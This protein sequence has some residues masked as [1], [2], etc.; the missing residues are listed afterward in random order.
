MERPVLRAV[1]R[2]AR[3][4]RGVRWL[5]PLLIALVGL[6]SVA[7]AADPLSAQ[8]P[9][10]PPFELAWSSPESLP[11]SSLAWGDLDNDGDLDLAVGNYERPIQVYRNERGRL[12]LDWES[13][14]EAAE[15]RHDRTLS[16]AWGDYDS[17]G[18]LDLIAG[19]GCDIF[20]DSFNPLG[21]Q[22]RLYQNVDGALGTT[23]ALSLP[24]LD[25][26]TSVAWGDYDND[27]RPDLAVG[28]GAV[29]RDAFGILNANIPIGEPDRIYRNLTGLDGV[30]RFVQV[31]QS[32]AD[33]SLA[34]PTQSVAWGDYNGDGR[35]DLAVGNAA[36]LEETCLRLSLPARNCGDVS[37]V[38]ANT[39]PPS[40]GDQASF[41]PAWAA[42]ERSVGSSVAW[43]DV[44]GDGLL[45][46]ALGNANLTA[47]ESPLPAVPNRIYL[48]RGGTLIRDPRW[49]P[50]RIGAGGAEQVTTL[51]V[52]WADYDGDGNLDLATGNAGAPGAPVVGGANLLFRNGGAGLADVPAWESPQADDTSAVAWGDVDGDGRPDMAAGNSGVIFSEGITGQPNRVYRNRIPPLERAPSWTAAPEAVA[53]AVALGDL[54]GDRDLDLVVVS[55][56]ADASPGGPSASRVYRNEGGVLVPEL[57]WQPVGGPAAVAALGDLDA[58]GNLDLAIGYGCDWRWPGC[59]SIRIYRNDGALL[60]SEPAWTA[61]LQAPIADLAWGDID[62]D[63]DL[64]LAAISPGA[65]GLLYRNLGGTLALDPAW[66]PLPP[67]A[68]SLAWADI[69]RDSDL[70]LAVGND[71]IPALRDCRSIELYLN[72]AGR[73]DPVPSVALMSADRNSSLAWGDVDAD[74]DLDLAA[75][76]TGQPSRLYRNCT[77]RRADDGCTTADSLL[78][79]TP[80]WSSVNADITESIVWG[81]MDSDGDLDLAVG[82]LGFEAG[83]VTTQANRIYGNVD[84]ALSQEAVWEAI[85]RS[86]TTRLAWGDVDGDGG[87]DLA[88]VGK[89]IAERV[90]ADGPAVRLYLNRRINPRSQDNT[91][92]VRVDPPTAVP[93]IR[94][95]A[96]YATATILAS[97]EVTFTYTLTHPRAAPV[98]RVRAEY[99][100]DGGGAWREAI[101]AARTRTTDLASSP[102]GTEHR[103]VW[104]VF[105]SGVMGLND[106]VVLRIIAIP[107]VSQRP[108]YVNR[109]PERFVV[110]S[111]SATTTPF[112]LRGTQVRVVD[113]DGAPVQGAIVYLLEPGQVRDG[114]PLVDSL[115]RPFRTDA[116][117]Y[118]QGR[119][120]VRPGDRL[121][122]LAPISATETFTVYLTSAPPTAQGLEPTPV[123]APGVQ[124]LRVSARHPLI[125]FNLDLSLEWDG[126]NDRVFLGQLAASLQ[127]T[128]E[129]LYDL[130]EGQAALGAVT[131][132]HGRERWD[133]AHI[134]VYATN[135]LRP[136]A[137]KG[138]IVTAVITDPLALGAEPLTPPLTYEPGQVRMG[139]VWNRYGGA[140]ELV[141]DWARTLAHELGHFA[142][143]L[144]DNYLGLNERGQLVTVESCRG[145]MADPYLDDNT[146]FVPP[147]DWLPGCAQT[148]SNQATRITRDDGSLVAEGRSDWATITTFYPWL[149]LPEAAFADLNSGPATLPLAVMRLSEVF[150]TVAA[151]PQATMVVPLRQPDGRSY[152]ASGSARAILFHDGRLIDLGRPTLDQVVVRGSARGDRLCLYDPA[153]AHQGCLTITEGSQALTVEPAR[154]W[155]PDIVVTPVTSRTVTIN[156][157]GVGQGADLRV[158]LYPTNSGATPSGEQRLVPSGSVYSGTITLDQPSF[159]A[160]V[161]L[162]QDDLLGRREAI[163]DYLVG[164]NPG[165]KW[166]GF[167][168]RGSPGRKWAGFAPV[169]S[170]DGQVIMYDRRL[171]FEEGE[172]IA[173]QSASLRLQ[174]PAWALSV[175]KAYRLTQS[176]GGP[177]LAQAAINISYFERDLPPGTEGGVAVYFLA[178]GSDQW[179]RLA[180]DLNLLRNEASAQVRGVGLYALMTSPRV[181][182]GWN[183][184]GYPWPVTSTVA[185]A[186]GLM[187]AEVAYTTVYGYDQDDSIDPWKV[188]DLAAPDWVNDLNP[189]PGSPAPA[190]EYGQGYWVLATVGSLQ[191]AQAAISERAASLPV[192]PATYYAVLPAGEEARIGPGAQVEARI[193]AAVCGRALTRRVGDAVV[194]VVDVLAATDEQTS[195][196]GAPGRAVTLIVGGRTSAPPIAWENGRP[197]QIAWSPAPAPAF[198]K[199][200]LPLLGRP[201]RL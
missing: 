174:A 189:P 84:G 62:G 172:L 85:D 111:N 10:R 87:L 147:A 112:R 155:Q 92:I 14:P 8:A 128:S 139:T 186:L 48:N 99:S 40:Q 88:A 74:G 16:V 107:A 156:V 57:G 18:D 55:S 91:S 86:V 182:P 6:L 105:R 136:S 169:L 164:G 103:F 130:S 68:Q 97:D 45:D 12:K 165:R 50:G 149:A 53:T 80:V 131:I 162:W 58:D 175:G 66:R 137:V 110:G 19:N 89:F 158:R 132:Y 125:L 102:E 76:N 192:P 36:L 51:S 109:T 188:F 95:A 56:D 21:Q 143:F 79:A 150:P 81:D 108:P 115:D 26:T 146:E 29:L 24:E 181:E 104:D 193:G 138:G 31:W 71:C 28:N 185:E 121:V 94:G 152:Q 5:A 148:L 93:P 106:Q 190:L 22:E 171:D 160:Y 180:T 32:T 153:R 101:P 187:N 42:D 54:D 77:L 20:N 70:D 201:T 35:L 184:L 120:N 179:E 183:Q 129:L 142:L 199:V 119:S 176:A 133:T 191:P 3:P 43:G 59:S 194:F 61:E 173:L 141:D 197:R 9:D 7:P 145:M 11:T 200:Y 159:E 38:Y 44:D 196:C 151:E 49:S 47:P 60:A 39:T 25:C 126:R 64:D 23:A 144:D 124:V 167:A 75:G 1:C 177:D 118:L 33:R 15:G 198:T 117:G 134:R 140:G 30:P 90:L 166:A 73:L 65:P 46:L 96:G 37:R 17:D 98:H 27:G 170:G 168:P 72:T 154:D 123:G 157:T 135:R 163:A 67:N 69:D 114:R 82:N 4:A 195:G 52:A 2:L 63:G 127:R 83:V 116:L 178:E 34:D 161:H 41:V 13:A 113:E 100:L 78:S 122:A